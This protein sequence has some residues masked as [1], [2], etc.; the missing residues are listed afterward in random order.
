MK[1]LLCLFFVPTLVSAAT[2]EELKLFA[3]HVAEINQLNVKVFL[4][5]ISCESSFN[6]KAVGLAGERSAVQYMP[7]TWLKHQK[8]LGYEGLSLSDPFAP[9]AIMGAVWKD[10]PKTKREWTCYRQV[11]A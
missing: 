7:L 11:S 2:P 3:R 9:I 5:T 1:Y 6:Y 8:L 4:A 10:Y